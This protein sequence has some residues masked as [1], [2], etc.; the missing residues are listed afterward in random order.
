MEEI[1]AVDADQIR[2]LVSDRYLREFGERLPGGIWSTLARDDIVHGYVD[3]LNVFESK[4]DQANVEQSVRRLAYMCVGATAHL[5]ANARK[6]PRRYTKRTAQTRYR[7]AI[8]LLLLELIDNYARTKGWLNENEIGSK[9]WDFD[10]ECHSGLILTPDVPWETVSAAWSSRFP[11]DAA[12]TPYA[13]QRLCRRALNELNTDDPVIRVMTPVFTPLR[14]FAR[15]AREKRPERLKECQT[16]VSMVADAKR[17]TPE[18]RGSA[19][20]DRLAEEEKALTGEALK[21]KYYKAKAKM[22]S[23]D[24]TAGDFAKAV[25][26]MMH[27]RPVPEADFRWPRP[28]IKEAK[29]EAQSDESWA[30]D[31]GV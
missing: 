2:K 17:A 31:T 27:I 9:R 13:F 3:G 30:P 15:R 7:K 6:E 11:R 29:L 22:K 21:R 26:A 24:I 1:E 16:L 18:L 4:G 8:T 20:W 14:G 10:V 23:Q 5:Y 19:F 12:K 28:F 25:G